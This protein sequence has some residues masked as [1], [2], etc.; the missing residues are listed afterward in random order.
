MEVELAITPEEL[1]SGLMYRDKLEDNKGMLFVFPKERF[2]SFWMKNTPLPLSIAFVKSDGRIV[3]IES[4]KPYSL[5]THLSKEK[6][7]YALEMKDGW[8]TIN[9]VKEG[10]IAKIPVIPIQKGID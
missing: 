7:M 2:L 9:K 10:D 8:F 5:D 4:M 6:V 1:A 3:Q